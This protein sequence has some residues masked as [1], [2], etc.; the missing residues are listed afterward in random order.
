MRITVVSL[1]PVYPAV[2]HG[3]GQDLF[4]LITFLGQRHE[5]RVVTFAGAGQ[6]QAAER[7]RPHVVALQVVRPAVTWR[8]KAARAAAALRRAQWRTL[9][10]R[11][12]GE[13]RTFIAATAPDVLYCV[14]TETGRYLQAAAPATVRVLDEVD[15]R[16]V[17]EEAAA[18]TVWARRRAA[19]RRAA[20]LG[21]CDNADLVVTRSARDLARLQAARPGLRG[22]V[23]PPVAHVETFLEIVP[24]TAEAG[25]VLFVGAMERARN[26][27]AARWLASAVWPQVRAACPQA[28]LRI[29]GASP[30]PAIRAL[31]QTPGVAVTGW[32]EDLR[33]EYARA[34]VVVAPQQAEAGALNKVIDGLA[35]GRP[36]VATP[37]ANSGV[38][39]PAD[40]IWVAETAEAFA[41]AMISLLE[42]DGA[43]KVQAEAARAFAAATFD[44][45]RAATTLEK[46]LVTLV[47]ERRRGD[48]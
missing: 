33:A 38:G 32:V 18:Q 22:L 16:F 15:V 12:E 5:V 17:V 20:E 10:R 26:Q 30:P 46:T 45:K 11:A 27:E 29:V 47:D 7:L 21:Y 44:W 31:A 23:L 13:V 9:G 14:W 43:W 3:G 39:A 6:A 48:L 40:A 19:R 42:D 41:A 36:V 28:T 2:A 24:G 34:R 25:R 4:H 37:P 1:Y 35:A 8:T